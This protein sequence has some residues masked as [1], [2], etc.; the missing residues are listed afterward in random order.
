MNFV[1]AFSSCLIIPMYLGVY[2]A[3]VQG[4]GEIVRVGIYENQPKVFIDETGKPAGF[5][6][7]LLNPIAGSKIG[8][9]SI[10]PVSGINA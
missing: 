8:S 7:D 5:W 1:A 4:T 9:C 10:S 3:P 2:A 6:V